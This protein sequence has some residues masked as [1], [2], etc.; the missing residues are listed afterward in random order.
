M[1]VHLYRTIHS[2]YVPFTL[3]KP[4]SL[5]LISLLSIKIYI[6]SAPVIFVRQSYCSAVASVI[7]ASF[8]F[9]F[10]LVSILFLLLKK[11]LCTFYFSRLCTIVINY[12][13]IRVLRSI[14]MCMTCLVH[15]VTSCL[16]A[17]GQATMKC[18]R[19]VTKTLT[20]RVKKGVHQPVLLPQGIRV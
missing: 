4:N 3:Y 12:R 19:Q 20:V 8:P 5:P 13:P 2:S 18:T 14:V 16:S 1:V 7:N 17:T 9:N 10:N 15:R 6:Q 11:F